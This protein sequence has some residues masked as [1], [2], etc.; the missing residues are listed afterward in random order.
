MFVGQTFVSVFYVHEAV[1]LCVYVYS[2]LYTKLYTKLLLITL[3]DS[4]ACFL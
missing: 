3:K 1:Q 2:K 4:F